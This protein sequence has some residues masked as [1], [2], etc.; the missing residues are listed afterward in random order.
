[1]MPNSRDGIVELEKCKVYRGDRAGLKLK[2]G[3]MTS[4]QTN[5]Y[6]LQGY[7]VGYNEI[8]NK[9]ADIV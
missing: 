4:K 9:A 8:S 1:M 3:K 7:L 6:Y 5:M 2:L